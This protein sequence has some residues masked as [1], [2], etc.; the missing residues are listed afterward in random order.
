MLTV[1]SLFSTK[2]YCDIPVTAGCCLAN[3][4]L[5]VALLLFPPVTD[6]PALVLQSGH[7]GSGS[8]AGRFVCQCGKTFKYSY[9]LYQHQRD[10]HGAA[11]IRPRGAATSTLM[12]MSNFSTN[13]QPVHGQSYNTGMVHK[14]ETP[15][16]PLTQTPDQVQS[17]F[18]VQEASET[19]EPDVPPDQ[20]ENSD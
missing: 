10:K 8:R 9:N 4:S 1:L 19:Q 6:S 12:A 15:M 17:A 7:G 18:D 2:K 20:A 5:P 14:P 16:S 11:H 3:P 13:L